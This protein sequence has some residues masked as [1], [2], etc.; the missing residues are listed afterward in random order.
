M[1]AAV[2][3][4]TIHL[5]NLSRGQSGSGCPEHLEHNENNAN[6]QARPWAVRPWAGRRSVRS[7]RR[8]PGGRS[9]AVEQRGRPAAPVVR[10]GVAR[11]SRDAGC[12]A[13]QLTFPAKRL[14]GGKHRSRRGRADDRFGR[15]WSDRPQQADGAFIETATDAE[16]GAGRLVQAPASSRGPSAVVR[17]NW[18]YR[19]WI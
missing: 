18:T 4:Q 17:F 10:R 19:L 11:P 14:D 1:V 5:R 6:G 12:A 8:S 7:S 15:S 2:A 16:G 13:H 9:A 3:I